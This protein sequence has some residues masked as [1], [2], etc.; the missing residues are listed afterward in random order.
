VVSVILVLIGL[1]QYTLSAIALIIGLHFYPMAKIFDR[2]V[3]YYVATWTCLVAINSIFMTAGNNYSQTFIL[4]ILGIGV[5]LA[6]STYGFY[7]LFTGYNY[8]KKQ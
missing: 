1:P 2:K 3:D 4:T 8:I 6:T 7:M 5:A